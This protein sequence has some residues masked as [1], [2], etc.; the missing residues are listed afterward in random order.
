[1]D[2][3]KRKQ[4]FESESFSTDPVSAQDQVLSPLLTNHIFKSRS[5]NLN[6]YKFWAV[7]VTE[8]YNL[9]ENFS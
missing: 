1:M 3:S 5:S 4:G 9:I 2:E 7:K 6:F 8:E